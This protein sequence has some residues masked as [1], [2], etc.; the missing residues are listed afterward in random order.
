MYLTRDKLLL[1]LPGEPSLKGAANRLAGD[2]EK[3]FAGKNL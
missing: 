3:Y 2:A 1:N